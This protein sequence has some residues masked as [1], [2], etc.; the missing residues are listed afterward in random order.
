MSSNQTASG[1]R[2][3]LAICAR[4]SEKFFNATTEQTGPCI[5]IEFLA[6]QTVENVTVATRQR[7]YE[8]THESRNESLAEKDVQFGCILVLLSR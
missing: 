3:H 5:L 8:E 7:V 4:D 6:H 2:S 1:P